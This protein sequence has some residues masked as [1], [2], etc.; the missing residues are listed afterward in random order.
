MRSFFDWFRETVSAEEPWLILGKGPSFAL[1][2]RLDMSGYRT[3]SLNHAAREQPVLLAH[4]I[5]LDV[6]DMIG[7]ALERNARFLVMPWYPHVG[8]GFGTR[9]L[10]EMVEDVPLL[11]R[12]E[13]EDRLLW[14]D[15]STS[16]VR[17][18]SDPVVEA[19]YF[20]AE[21]ALNLL[22]MAGV[23]QVRSLGVDGGSAYSGAFDDLRDST[24][25]ANGRT[26]FDLQFEGFART[27]VHTGVDFA[28]LD[29][30]TPARV[31]VAQGRDEA[32]QLKVLEHSIRRRASLTVEVIPVSAGE[33]QRIPDGDAVIL[34]ARAQILADL[35]PLWKTGIGERDLLIPR[36]SEPGPGVV[37]AG[38]GL[39][40]RVTDLACQV[41]ERVPAKML[42]QIASA[43]LRAAL[44]P[45]WNPTA[46]RS[47]D[48]GSPI[49]FY[50]ADGSEPWLSRS[51]PL[52]HLWM[53]DLL[54]GISLGFISA[55]MVAEEVRHGHVRPSLLYQI[56]QGLEE[57]LLLPR[58]ARQLDRGFQAPQQGEV[59]ASTRQP[60]WSSILQAVA[61]QV[62]RRTRAMRPRSPRPQRPSDSGLVIR[63]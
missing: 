59:K 3:L 45:E 13:A 38:A 5:D 1:R 52:G 51:H 44:A 50:P 16:P 24:L 57:P 53:R 2:D 10:A 11:R 33:A 19:T 37:L 40:D 56:D 9:S 27:I 6:V 39:C 18:G 36:D 32:L 55:E 28:P 17:Y 35:R 4:V 41:L 31:Y 23:R 58:R 34:T 62:A 60:R 42:A 8:N 12:F 21:A 7:T 61:R 63:P 49:L 47:P 15:L 54:D 25:L 43:T 26:S 29:R 20:S 22:A 30:P 46:S 14:Y 48:S